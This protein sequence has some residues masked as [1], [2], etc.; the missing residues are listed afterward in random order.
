MKPYALM[1]KGEM[2]MGEGLKIKYNVTKIEDG[3]VVNDCFVLRPNKDPAAV[4]ALR[5]Y[6]KATPNKALAEDFLT[7]VILI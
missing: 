6:A 3:S 7:F 2:I 1:R 5:A 4:E